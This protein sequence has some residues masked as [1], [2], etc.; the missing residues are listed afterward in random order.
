M[1]LLRLA[2]LMVRRHR[3]MITSWLVLLIALSGATVSAY[4]ST[5]ATPEQ[6]RAATEL[7]QH[8]AASNLLYGRLADPGTPAQ[9]FGWEIG[10]FVTILAAVM[11][12]LVATALT[13][14]TEDDGTL[15]LERSCGIDPR[16]PLRAAC[17]VLLI[18]AATLALGCAV[19]L[20]LSVGH[21]DAVTWP[22]AVAFGA[23]V[24]LT[25]L[26]TGVLTVVLAQVAPTAAGT[27]VLGFAAER[28][29]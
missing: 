16:V 3:L 24:G 2:R 18:V 19:A 10:A 13:R 17:T 15:E 26:V 4:Q 21:V 22:G 5:Y 14:A 28:P 27:R 8:N 6:R 7:A 11:A 25:F 12:V 20:G 9:M 23:V 1:S 29:Y